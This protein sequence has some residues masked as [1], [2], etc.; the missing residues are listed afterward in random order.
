MEEDIIPFQVAK[1]MV[2]VGSFTGE[3][4]EDLYVWISRFDDEEQRIALN[5]AVYESD[6]WKGVIAPQI[7]AMLIREKIVVT[8]L[9]PT[10]KSMIR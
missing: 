8:R 1:G 9:N 2:I 7:P 4:E 6:H 5:A 3:A 10:P